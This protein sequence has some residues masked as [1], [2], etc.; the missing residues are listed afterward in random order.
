ML[1]RNI[2]IDQRPTSLRVRRGRIEAIT[3]TLS[4]EPGE[5]VVDGGGGAAIPGLHDH[6][7]HLFALAASLQSV[8]CGPPLDADGLAARIR[9]AAGDAAGGWIRGV[10]YHEAVA[11]DIDRAFLDACAGDVPVRV[12]HRSG[13]LWILN[14]AA[15]DRLLGG[16]SGADPLERQG[17]ILTGRLYDGDDWLAGRLGQAWPSL[18]RVGA[19]L[20]QR[21]VTGLTE[22]GHANDPTTFAALRQ[23]RRRGEITQDLLVFGRQSLD[24]VDGEAGIRPGAVKFHLHDNALPDIDA[25]SRDIA[26]AHAVGRAVA[27]HCVTV[28]DLVLTL[29]CLA[30]VG[31]R[32]GDRIEHASLVPPDLID[33]MADLGV[34]VVTQPHFIAERGDS[35]RTSL[36]ADEIPWL[37]RVRSLIDAGVPLAAGS[38]APYGRPD[39]WASMQAAVDR[40]TAAGICL[41][42]GERLS[43]EAALALYTSPP[44]DPGGAPRRLAVGAVADICLLDRSWARACQALAEVEV[45]ITLKAGVPV[46][47]DPSVDRPQ[48]VVTAL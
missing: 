7:I 19:L 17:G 42:E 8:A 23:A 39:P 34:T 6:H 18:T 16:G 1:I 47:T 25:F 10:A 40:R 28:A 2:E 12:Q 31:A 41:G 45:R 44:D 43:A 27:V 15:L 24:V 26:R 33:W 4:A 29:S 46:W 30:D 35:Y 48:S 22:T 5:R 3:P 20:A 11:G 9:V 37:Y 38:D 32:V 36:G 13:R 14:S 21:G